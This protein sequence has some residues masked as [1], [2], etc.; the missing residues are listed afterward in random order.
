MRLLNIIKALVFTKLIHKKLPVR[1]QKKGIINNIVNI[2][3]SKSFSLLMLGSPKYDK[4]TE[5]HIRI[6]KTICLKNGIIFNFMICLPN[7]DSKVIN[8]PFLAI[9]DPEIKRCLTEENEN[10]NISSKT[11]QAEFDFVESTD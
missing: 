4:K 1:L 5:E 9:S 3:P 8:N 6:K 11:I 2:D 10:N 7:D